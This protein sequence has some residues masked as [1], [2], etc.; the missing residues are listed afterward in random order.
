MPELNLFSN[1]RDQ[2]SLVAGEVLFK[3]GDP[4][5]AMYGVLEGCIALEHKGA[6][7]ENVE[8]G[9]FLGEL[10]LIDASERSAS[11]SAVVDSRLA[12]VDRRQFEFLVTEHPTFAL[13][14]MEVMAARLRRANG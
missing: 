6:T 1:S 7:L 4:A 12:R 10:A 8:A 5:D 3:E 13:R 2:V 11:A 9:G 14:V